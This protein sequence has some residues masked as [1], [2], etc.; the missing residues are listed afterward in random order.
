MRANIAREGSDAVLWRNTA[1]TATERCVLLLA[2]RSKV[3]PFASVSP[4]SDAQRSGCRFRRL[5]V[6][7]RRGA[8]SCPAGVGKTVHTGDGSA[9]FRRRALTPALAASS[10]GPRRHSGPRMTRAASNSQILP[11]GDKAQHD[12]SLDSSSPRRSCAS[13]ARRAV[14]RPGALQV[15]SRRGRPGL[16]FG[17]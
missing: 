1:N 8:R 5:P 10:S 16:T 7:R 14:C 17:R 12:A 13:R 3:D 11:F 6:A 4:K 9:A 2:R 15:G